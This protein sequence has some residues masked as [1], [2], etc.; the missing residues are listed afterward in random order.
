MLS[1]A[2][3]TRRA[4]GAGVRRPDHWHCA[5][6]ATSHARGLE[7]LPSIAEPRKRSRI[8]T[9]A[10]SRPRSLRHGARQALS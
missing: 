4:L 6:A 5:R 2:P 1:R 8:A 7:A 3:W 9:A 10:H